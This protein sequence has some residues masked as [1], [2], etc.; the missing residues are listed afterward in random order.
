MSRG[1]L[2]VAEHM[3]GA[4]SETTLQAITAAIEMKADGAGPISVCVISHDP[5]ALVGS[6]SVDG[7]DSIIQ[8]EVPVAEF[9]SDMYTAALRELVEEMRPAVVLLASSTTGLALGPGVAA[10]LGLGFAS[11]VVACTA[12]D[13]TITARRPFYAG[14]V[15]AELEFPEGVPV[16]LL[17]RS[18]AWAPALVG[19]SATISSFQASDGATTSRLRHSGFVDP[20]A[21]EFDLTKS[22]VIL[23]IGRGVGERDNIARFEALAERM[24]VTLA[25]SRPLVDAGWIPHSRQVGQSGV[26]VKPRLYIA[27]GISGAMQHIIGM[28]GSDVVMAINKDPHAPIFG[29]AQVGATADIF[30]V[31]EELEL[32]W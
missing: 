29:V 24:G 5:P 23:A 14:K 4:V 30:D 7:I 32:L 22:D 10:L 18:G 6:V 25:S 11:D 9:D 3:R 31:A 13:G 16:V 19:G 1:I 15:E 2:V 21:D 17:L 8:V 28:K 12:T 20:V 26:T 27:M